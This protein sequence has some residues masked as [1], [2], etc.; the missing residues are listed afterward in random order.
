M[1]SMKSFLAHPSTYDRKL[2]AVAYTFYLGSGK[3]AEL[4]RKRIEEIIKREAI[5]SKKAVVESLHDKDL[6]FL[7]E[8]VMDTAAKNAGQRQSPAGFLKDFPEDAMLKL[9]ITLQDTEKG[10]EVKRRIV[11]IFELI[12]KQETVDLFL[13]SLANQQNHVLR[14]VIL[15]SLKRL[16]QRNEMLTVNRFLVKN[17]IAKETSL[18]EALKKMEAFATKRR[19]AGPMTD[20]YGSVLLKAL[21]DECIERIFLF[22]ELLYSHEM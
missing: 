20:P 11:R 5:E 6:K 8:S 19:E 12:P 21:M 18:Y 17:E 3:N 9:S 1:E 7:E 15:K 16:H 4:T 10:L 13:S 14:Y 2:S 22:L